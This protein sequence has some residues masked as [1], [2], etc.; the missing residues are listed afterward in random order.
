MLIEDSHS[1]NDWNGFESLTKKIGDKIICVGDDLLVTNSN[2][3]KKAIKNKTVNG[4]LLKVNQIGSL[5]ESIDAVKLSKNANWSV[6]T[7]HRSGETEDTF[8]SD[9]TVGLATGLIKSGAPCRSERLAKYNQFLRI[10]QELANNAIYAGQN[11]RFP[12][13]PY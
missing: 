1:E 6:M 12:C 9:L 3:I 13:E 5:T 11:Y 10:E 8:I 7:S 4:L 2:R